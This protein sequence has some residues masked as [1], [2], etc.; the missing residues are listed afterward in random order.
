MLN[1]L[2]SKPAPIP[3]SVDQHPRLIEALKDLQKL[4]AAAQSARDARDRLVNERA[5]LDS[6]ATIA[7]VSLGRIT[8]ADVDERASVLDADIAKAKGTADKSDHAVKQFE[9]DVR[10]L[11]EEVRAEI[12][13][14]VIDLARSLLLRMDQAFVEAGR[15][16]A[17]IEALR[18]QHPAID[19]PKYHN[20]V[21]AVANDWRKEAREFGVAL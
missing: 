20:Y 16:G 6:Q 10:G 5:A 3:P 13:G 14:T 17:E 2:V 18:A 21:L 19:L 9:V 11:R 1:T 4:Q 15:A 12:K 7:L 8:Q